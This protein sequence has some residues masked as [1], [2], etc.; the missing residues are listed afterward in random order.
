MG[1][2][3]LN[4]YAINI[5][6][7]YGNISYNLELSIPGV[8]HQLGDVD[9]PSPTCSIVDRLGTGPARRKQV[10]S[11]T[12]AEDRRRCLFIWSAC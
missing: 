3:D 9:P 7:E 2:R 6:N 12:P 4:V 5:I 10:E 1:I 11:K 8:T